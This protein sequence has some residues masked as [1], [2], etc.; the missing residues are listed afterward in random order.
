M[1]DE[2][3]NPVA[4]LSLIRQSTSHFPF[5]DDARR[6][7]DGAKT[8]DDA[9]YRLERLE[10]A[11]SART[12]IE[13]KKREMTSRREKSRARDSLQDSTRAP[14]IPEAVKTRRMCK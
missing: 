8:S 6:R 5:V 14:G 3:K 11:R 7:V 1:R 2:E 10:V 13:E 12:R 4:E 9:K